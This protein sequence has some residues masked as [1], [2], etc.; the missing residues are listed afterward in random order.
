MV[1]VVF[2][3]TALT[4][5]TENQ[6]DRGDQPAQTAR[7]CRECRPSR[8]RG[9]NTGG[10]LNVLFACARSSRWSSVVVVAGGPLRPGSDLLSVRPNSISS[11]FS[12]FSGADVPVV[13][14]LEIL[15]EDR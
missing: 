13:E 7:A 12:T 11:C 6:G 4:S 3:P 8:C 5:F 1:N 14:V 15:S 2:P 9:L 10:Y